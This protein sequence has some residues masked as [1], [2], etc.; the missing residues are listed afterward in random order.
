MTTQTTLASRLRPV[1]PERPLHLRSLSHP[2]SRR[3]AEQIFA[4]QQVAEALQRL[5]G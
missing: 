1:S 2:V 3:K 4:R 5:G